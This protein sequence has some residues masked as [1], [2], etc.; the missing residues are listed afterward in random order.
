MSSKP[1]HCSFGE[2]A[3]FWGPNL[4]TITCTFAGVFFFCFEVT[5]VWVKVGSY[6]RL[7]KVAGWS[8]YAHTFVQ[9]YKWDVLASVVTS[10]SFGR[11]RDS[12][13]HFPW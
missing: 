12:L 11:E 3:V 2:A 13:S 6:S 4:F 5:T 7:L 10:T 8:L 1:V 9:C